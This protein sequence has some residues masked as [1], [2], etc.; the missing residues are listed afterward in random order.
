MDRLTDADNYK[1]DNSRRAQAFKRKNRTFVSFYSA[2][3]RCTNKK[4]KSYKNYGGRGIKCLFKSYRE[5][6]DDIGPRPMGCSLGRI[7]NNGHYEKGNIRWETLEEQARNKRNN[8]LTPFKII[9]AKTL[10]AL[11]YRLGV[12]S[13]IMSVNR[14]T[15]GSMF[16]GETWKG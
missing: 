6:I 8:T 16:R 11:G 7:D 1:N 4:Q 12:I 2:Q 5:I 14:T 3:Q 15:L 9:F 13:S 10:K